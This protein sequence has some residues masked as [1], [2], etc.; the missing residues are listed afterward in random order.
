MKRYFEIETESGE[1]V[2][3]LP[4]KKFTF[5]EVLVGDGAVMIHTLHNALVKDYSANGV[6]AK[7]MLRGDY[8]NE[9]LKAV[10]AESEEKL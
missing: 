10:D 6:F 5:K 8:S 9:E 2:K 1:K 7:F 4:H 3:L